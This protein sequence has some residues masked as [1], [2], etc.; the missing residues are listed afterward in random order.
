MREVTEASW[1]LSDD[2]RRRRYDELRAQ[3]GHGGRAER[4][5]TGDPLG[6]LLGDLLGGNGGL[7]GGGGLFGSPLGSRPPEGRPAR[8]DPVL[9]DR[10]ALR[11][12]P[13]RTLQVIA[14]GADLYQQREPSAP[15]YAEYYQHHAQRGR[16]GKRDRQHS[17]TMA[18]IGHQDIINHLFA[19]EAP[20]R[21]RA[22]MAEAILA[23][24][25][26]RY[27]GVRKVEPFDP[28]PM[29]WRVK[30]IDRSLTPAAVADN[31]ID[32]YF[33]ARDRARDAQR[34]D[35]LSDAGHRFGKVEHATSWARRFLRAAQ[36]PEGAARAREVAS[37][38]L[39]AVGGPFIGN[40]VAEGASRS[41]WEAAMAALLASHA[42]ASRDIE[43]YPAGFSPQSGSVAS[44]RGVRAAA[45]EGYET[46][47]EEDRRRRFDSP[48]SRA[49]RGLPA[50]APAAAPPAPV[51]TP[52]TGAAAPGAM[53]GAPQRI[54]QAPGQAPGLGADAIRPG[55]HR[56]TPPK[57]GDGFAPRRG[58]P[59]NGLQGR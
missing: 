38:A 47:L 10:R 13:P 59:G 56:R 2:G 5:G 17:V 46:A 31:T 8:V 18:F 7:F 32:E 37:E 22:A 6:G 21:V 30:E 35:S 25:A 20:E 44:P 43:P 34:V 14:R 54:D 55:R 23:E 57:G 45:R 53:P 50:P 33:R 48:V 42:E 58:E 49:D 1:V 15:T 52:P 40:L 36:G 19:F 24:V 16:H 4:S 29:S 12:D 28:R 9:T 51:G 39:D 27:V 41:A 26:V 11:Q 3:I